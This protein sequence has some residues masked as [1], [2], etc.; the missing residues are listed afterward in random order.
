MRKSAFDILND[1]E[2]EVMK[3]NMLT[4]VFDDDK[5]H[6]W[7]VKQPIMETPKAFAFMSDL[8]EQI[9]INLQKVKFY[10]FSEPNNEI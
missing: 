1:R 9:C 7:I 3:R 10:K 2:A 6:S 8:D 4:V 5:I